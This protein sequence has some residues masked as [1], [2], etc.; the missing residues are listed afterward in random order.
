VIESKC[1]GWAVLFGAHSRLFWA[2][3]SPDGRPIPAQ[4]ASELLGPCARLTV[5]GSRGPTVGRPAGS[6][7]GDMSAPRSARRLRSSQ[8]CRFDLTQS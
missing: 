4:S 1:P 8:R 2:F 7:S 5:P 6:R 3:G